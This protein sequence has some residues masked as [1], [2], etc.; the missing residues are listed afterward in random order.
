MR[1]F[2]DLCTVLNAGLVE[3]Y[4]GQ[5]KRDWDNAIPTPDVRCSI[6][7][8]DSA[9]DTAARTTSVTSWWFAT[10]PET[11]L[12]RH[13]RIEWDGLTLEVDGEV[14]VWKRR[15]RP[16]RLEAKLTRATDQADD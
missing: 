5:Q 13:S 6:Q 10:L 2:S 11:P 12:D 7:P 4:G 3:G 16:Y 1:G 8:V 15:G 9:E 14:A